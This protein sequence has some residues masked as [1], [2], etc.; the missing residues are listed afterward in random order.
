MDAGTKQSIPSSPQ[1]KTK[2][3]KIIKKKEY[4]G[5]P[6]KNHDCSNLNYTFVKY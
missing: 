1:N 6:L 3:G 2:K 5:T 4:D